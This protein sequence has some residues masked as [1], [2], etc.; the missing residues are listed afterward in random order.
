MQATSRS[1]TRTRG[2]GR[3][4]AVGAL[5]TVP[6]LANVPAAT[7]VTIGQL[8]ASTPPATEC[9]VSPFDLVQ[10]TVTSGNSYVVPS[11]GGVT[12]LT[13]TSW[14]HFATTGN[15]QMLTMKVFRKVAEPNT[16]QVVAHDGPRSLTPASVNTFST[17]LAVKP[18]DILG[19]QDV[20]ASVVPNACT[21]PAAGDA[22]R[23]RPGDLADGASGDFNINSPNHRVN[24]TAEVVPTNTFTLGTLTRNKK[25]GT[26]T[27]TASV[28]NPGAATVS[29]N[30][31]KTASARAK[32][33]VSVA[34]AGTV[35]LPIRAQG[36]KKRKLNSSGKVKLSVTI[37][38]TPTGGTASTQ[39]L[40]VKLKKKI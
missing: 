3:L 39:T 37:T 27:D 36:K 5:A 13:L 25:K 10:P 29:G 6:L 28:P 34:A 33:A 15:G 26:A 38:Y 7:A 23:E 1:T 21:F 2:V 4:I 30:G 40:Q 14:S 32:T 16:Y 19:D 22:T 24:A 11:T 18:G 8:P 31:V 20:N 9:V 12:A 17:S 35:Q